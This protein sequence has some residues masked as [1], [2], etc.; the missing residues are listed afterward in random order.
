[1]FGLIS[2]SIVGCCL[3]VTLSLIVSR[4]L[5]RHKHLLHRRKLQKGPGISTILLAF[6]NPDVLRLMP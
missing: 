6:T 4:I 3:V 1:M 5:L 2:A